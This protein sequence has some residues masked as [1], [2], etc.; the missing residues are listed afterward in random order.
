MTKTRDFLKTHKALLGGTAILSLAALGCGPAAG[1]L[2][3][4]Y[5]VEAGVFSDFLG[6]VLS[7]MATNNVSALVDKLRNNPD[8]LKNQD[9]GRATGLAIALGIRAV[10]DGEEFPEW[11]DILRGLA[12]KT[13]DYWL[14]TDSSKLADK[15]LS[16]LDESQI[17]YAFSANAGDYDNLR[18]LDETQ[19]HIVIRGL[20][21]QHQKHLRADVAEY[22]P[23]IQAIARHLNQ[24]FAINL[25]EVLADD[26]VGKQAF[27]KM[28]LDLQRE[29]VGMLRHICDRLDDM[30]NKRE[31]T[32]QLRELETGLQQENRQQT[33]LLKQILAQLQQSP[34]YPKPEL[35]DSQGHRI[36]SLYNVPHLPPKFLPRPEELA[37]IK[38]KLLG[39]ASQKLVMTGVSQRLGVQGMGGIGKTL[40]ATAV[41]RDEEVQRQFPDGVMWVTLGETPDIVTRQT[42]LASYL[43]GNRPY[44]EDIPQGK[45]EL[46]Q[47]LA[48]KACL[49][50]LDDVWQMHHAAAFDVLGD[51]CQLLLTTRDA[52][53]ITG[54]GAQGHEVGL[55]TEGQALGLL[56]QWAGEHLETLPPEAAEVARECGYL[57]LAVAISGAMVA[58][59]GANRWQNVLHKLQTADLEKL[60]QQFPDYPY[61][62]LFKAIQVSVEALPPEETERYLDFAIFPEDTPI[63]EA[64]FVGFWA[65][66]GLTQ[67]DVQDVVDT[68]VKRSLAF[69]DAQGR[70]SL[71]DLQ[72]DYVRKQAGEIAPRQERF[73]NSYRQ[74]YPQ[75]YHTVEDD[76]YFFRHLISHHLQHRPEDIRH[77]LLDFPWLQAKLEA[78]DVKA[79]LLDFES[80]EGGEIGTRDSLRLVKSAIRMSATI[81]GKDKTQ[82]ISQLW[83]RL[84]SFIFPAAVERSEYRFFWEN[85]PLLG[86]YL[87]NYSQTPVEK[88]GQLL[89]SPLFKGKQRKSERSREST[90][91]FAAA[92]VPEI[93]QFLTQAK[94]YEAKPWF[95]PLNPSF[96]PAGGM[97]L[98]TLTGHNL[99]VEAVAITP[100]G[101]QAV[102]ASQD[103]TLKLWDLATGSELATLTGHSWSINAVAIT[104]DG[105]QAISASGDTTLKLWDLATAEELTTLTGHSDEVTAVAIT[106]DGKQVVSASGDTTLKLWDLTTGSELATLTGHSD[107][108]TAVAIT[109]DGKQVVSASGDTT[110]KLWDLATGSELAT[111]TGHSWSINAVAITPDGKQAISASGDTTLKL[112][113]LTTGSELAT[114]TGHS[115]EVTAVAITP[116]GKQAVSASW[117]KTLK[118][119]DLATGSELATLTGH[120][121]DVNAVAITPDGKQAI[122]ASE[123]KTLKLWDLATGPELVTLT[124]HS[125]SINAVAITPDGK[126]AVSASE[127]K[128][129]KLWDLATG[130]ELATLTGHR[131]RVNAVAIT[132]DGKQAV[133]ASGDK[134]L[135]L[136][137]LATG[138]EWAKL[139]GHSDEVTAVAITP[140]GKQAVSASWDTTLK[141]WDLATR[142]ELATLTGHRKSVYAVAITL[143]GKQAVS[144]SEDKTLKLWDLATRSELATL[145]GHR[146]SVYA[147]A[148]TPDGKQAVSA[149]G[150]KTLKLWDLAT[151][152]VVASFGGDGVLLDCAIS[153]DGVTVVA[154]GRLGRVHCLR[155]EG[156]ETGEE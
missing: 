1:M 15:G 150:D 29:T 110:L 70:I 135:K 122:S 153:P 105:K 137:D 152:D 148:I 145:T 96:T 97:L 90:G 17:R 102:S 55:L 53:L 74:R 149:S 32:A 118:L 51:N 100:D 129:L 126:Q 151:G 95:R 134:T 146:K 58:G 99:W 12:D 124:G 65:G 132:L 104:P 9:L 94:N 4:K 123:D 98:L 103:T 136:W 68:L 101:K 21:Q 62:T 82:L 93:E 40:L 107:E 133:S 49:L 33:R 84:L 13:V 64:V 34:L 11:R 114:L 76:G 10:A 89:L 63:P 24:R 131:N 125:W 143:D 117:D 69:R 141:L 20:M 38:Q 50:I 116:D 25:R 41:A 31:L 130:S 86:K 154:G 59:K 48:D 3:A 37:Q 119:W 106:P 75:G 47:L 77:L 144:A 16:P 120:G 87:P 36:A 121:R 140:D 6:N 111:L 39:N 57:P 45:A 46:R 43:L 80:V 44:F 139:V 52:E 67:Y 81:L 61:P 127:D 22:E 14:N 138:G 113:D 155:L 85:I 88:R 66:E 5:A 71:H 72:L 156:L 109:P 27:K 2:A 108:V 147:V 112:W 91:E 142:S 128:T 79:L 92:T 42:D 7:G 26:A 78:T 73:L 56:A 19:W 30:P 54:F 60:S 35:R 28:L 23:A 8:I 115:D 18:V 83:G